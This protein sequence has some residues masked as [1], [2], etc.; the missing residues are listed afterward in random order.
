M[1]AMLRMQIENMLYP[2]LRPYERKER[3]RLLKAASNTPHDLIEWTGILAALAFAGALTSYGAVDLHM[4][5]RFVVA[6]L[7]YFVAA[8]VLTLTAGPFLVRRTRRG[9][10]S[11][12]P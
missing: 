5:Q 9:L 4:P 3:D 6:V 8:A 7:N 12:L 11:H 2:E 1:L 10:R